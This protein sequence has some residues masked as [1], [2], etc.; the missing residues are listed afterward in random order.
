[1][2]GSASSRDL[3]LQ[4]KDGKPTIRQS[5]RGKCF[6]GLNDDTLLVLQ[7]EKESAPTLA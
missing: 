1:M 7:R 5:G 4:H 3:Y 6:R 2:I